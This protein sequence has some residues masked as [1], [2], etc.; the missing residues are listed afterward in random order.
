[1]L[2]KIALSLLILVSIIT[3]LPFAE[4]AA[5]GI[6]QTVSGMQR[7]HHRRHSRRWWRRHRRLRRAAQAHRS[8]PLM[9][10]NAITPAAKPAPGTPQVLSQLPNGWNALPAAPNGEIKFRASAPGNTSDLA[11]LA[12]V[13]ISQPNPDY[14]APKERKQRLGGV[15]FSELRRIVI[16]KMITSGGW[17]NNDYEREVGGHRVF[18]VTAQTPADGRTSEK[19]W[20]SY[21]T[22]VNGRIYSLTTEASLQSSERMAAEAEKFIA[23][24][25]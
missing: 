20:N 8:K 11:A 16:D 1:M 22:E 6:R 2:R 17:V 7:R 18:I 24:P 9:A 5:H 4:S 23:S 12:V 13:A 25:R 19:I 15:S 10:A 14:L 3:I 21:F